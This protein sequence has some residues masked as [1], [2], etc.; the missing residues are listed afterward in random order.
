MRVHPPF[1]SIAIGLAASIAVACSAVPTAPAPTSAAP[2]PSTIVPVPTPTFERVRDA[3]P[4]VG[5]PAAILIKPTAVPPAQWTVTVGPEASVARFSLP[6]PVEV[7]TLLHD[8]AEAGE[9]P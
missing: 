6:T 4:T 1:A 7:L 8:L 9:E 2:A 3:E 5:A